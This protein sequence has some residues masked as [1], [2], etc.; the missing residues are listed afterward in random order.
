MKSLNDTDSVR[1]KTMGNKGHDDKQ[2]KHT[3]TQYSIDH[4]LQQSL[5]ITHVGVSIFTSLK[6]F[7]NFG[8]SKWLGFWTIATKVTVSMAEGEVEQEYVQ[9]PSGFED[10]CSVALCILFV[11]KTS[12]GFQRSPIPLGNFFRVH[13]SWSFLVYLQHC[14][15]WWPVAVSTFS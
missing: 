13:V 11:Q 14:H 8:P 6:S 7:L 15:T 1:V 2:H 4:A 10:L 12:E 3:H 5:S 9:K